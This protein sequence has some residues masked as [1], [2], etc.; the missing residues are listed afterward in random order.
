MDELRDRLQGM[1]LDLNAAG[2]G[3]WL[4]GA[5]APEGATG[6]YHPRL[7]NREYNDAV[8]DAFRNVR[9]LGQAQQTLQDIRTQLQDGSFPG[10]RPR[11]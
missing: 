6:A 3:V 2:N 5:N 10:V 8:I 9:T 11:P 7:N 1:G 4:P